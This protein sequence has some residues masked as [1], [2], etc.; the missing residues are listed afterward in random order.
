MLDENFNKTEETPPILCHYEISEEEK[1]RRRVKRYSYTVGTAF[2]VMSFLVTV[3]NDGVIYIMRFFGLSDFKISEIVNEPAIEQL[4]QIV[5]T[6]VLFTVPFIVIFKIF[7]FNISDIV[8]LKPCKKGLLLP[9]LLLGL[10]LCSFANIAS[11]YL[12]EF[13]D[14]FGVNY[15]VDFGSV[16]KG[17]FG[18]ALAFISTVITPALF[19]EFA[20]RGIVLGAGRKISPAFAV[21]ASATVFGLM[22]ANFEQIPFAL[23]IGL[24]L[25]FVTLKSGS[26]WTAVL[27]HGINNFVSLAFSTFLGKLSSN[28]Q[29]VVYSAYLVLSLIGIIIAMAWLK[30]KEDIFSL[31]TEKTAL[32]LKQKFKIFFLNPTVIIYA[33]ICIIKSFKYFV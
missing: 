15:E 23:F 18:F 26:M 14:S 17:V 3:L 2:I 29:I 16:P 22:H 32:P 12:G 25:G 5:L 13:V 8:S 19:E 7:G 30:D 9:F 11:S 10:G 33:V 20:C 27:I 4:L 21:V 24:V 31:D 1:E 6:V 28:V